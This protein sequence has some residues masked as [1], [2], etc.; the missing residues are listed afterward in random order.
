MSWYD[1]LLA[2][3][4]PDYAVRRISA[5]NVVSAYESAKTSRTHKPKRE[6]RGPNTP[7]T[8]SAVSLRQQGRYL[9]QNNDIAKG[10]L[11]ILVAR[12]VGMGILPE[13]MVEDT[14]GDLHEEVNE[15]L[16]SL[17]DEWCRRPEVTWT[18]DEPSAQRMS[19]RTYFR[20]GEYLMQHLLGNTRGL[21]HGTK[22]PYSYE[23]IESDMLPMHYHK[24]KP[25]VVSGVEMNGWGR[26][27]AYHLLKSDPNDVSKFSRFNEETRVIPASK[28]SHLAIRNRFRQVRGTSVFA[29]VIKRL[30]DINEIDE[31]ERVA[32]RMAAAIALYIK[33]G[34]PTIYSP[35]DSEAGDEDP[36]E[37]DIYP[38]MVIDDLLPGED[39]GSVISN[40]PNNQLIAF[41]GDQMRHA[42]AGIGVSGS[43]LSKNYNGTYSA[44]R[45]ELVEQHDHYGILWQD[46]IGRSERPKLENFINM[47][48]A[49]RVIRIPDNVKQD[50]LLNMN[51]S[52]P[53]MPWIQPKQEAEGWMTLIEGKLESRSAVIRSRGKNPRQVDKQIEREER[54]NAQDTK[55][56]EDTPEE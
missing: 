41:K 11:D 56:P 18:L 35:P 1:R 28:I 51:F 37:I 50:T 22:V 6:D 24:Q 19:A 45:Q 4:A 38:G 30:Q 39:V 42:A 26:P 29:V 53:A 17:Y 44:Q 3:I 48:I 8:E 21:Q 47:A 33:K 46:F 54:K 34:D 27:T 43:A 16:A 12:T 32:A 15:Q 40:R 5:K 36:R 10:A 20:D 7:V 14:N 9:E 55:D 23:L 52:R 49:S 13:F 25:L 2:G 31:T